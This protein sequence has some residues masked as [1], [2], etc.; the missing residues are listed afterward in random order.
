MFCKEF[1]KNKRVLVTGH[2]GFKGSWLVTLLSY[3]GAK[4]SGYS[5]LPDTNP[6]LYSLIN[7]SDK[8]EHE[9]I[10]DICNLPSLSRFVQKVEPEIVFHL[11]AQPLVLESYNDPVGTY[12]SNVLGTLNILEA[13]RKQPSI[14]SVVII[15]TDKVYE[16]LETGKAFKENDPLGGYDMYSSSK[17]CCEILVSSYRRSFL[18]DDNS[19]KVATARAGNVIG[20]GDFAKDRIVPDCIRALIKNEVI[21]L[22][23]PKST[24]PWQHVLEPLLGYLTLAQYLFENS[25]VN[26]FAFNFGPDNNNITT[27]VE[28][29]EKIS[30]IWDGGKLD[31]HQ[32]AVLHEA[33]FLSLDNSKAKEVLGVHPIL[34]VDKALLYTTQWYKKWASGSPNLNDFSLKQIENF[35]EEAGIY[36]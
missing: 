16:N 11:A 29:A 6:R 1:F 2:A 31:Y 15:T 18:S 30:Y 9:C 19:F 32:S 28:L 5:L 24:R 20:G 13:C 25:S 27:V 26:D 36:D 34:S 7:I 3:L 4:V 12:H 17:A 23:N 33:N 22:R 35:L 21:K 14:K 8:L 10:A